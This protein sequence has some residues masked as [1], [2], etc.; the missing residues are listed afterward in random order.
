MTSPSHNSQVYGTGQHLST[1]L[2]A[3]L[4]QLPSVHDTGAPNSNRVA[5][6]D[7]SHPPNMHG[8]RQQLRTKP[9]SSNSDSFRTTSLRHLLLPPDPTQ[10]VRI[11]PDTSNSN[12]TPFTSFA[13][14]SYA[15]PFT[16]FTPSSTQLYLLASH[17]RLM[18]NNNNSQTCHG[19]L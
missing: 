13:S 4:S 6:T 10:Q 1:G 3:Y 11:G 15:T 9:N 12:T 8:A 18:L 7:L 14:N 2:G 16:G 17:R 19:M 5:M